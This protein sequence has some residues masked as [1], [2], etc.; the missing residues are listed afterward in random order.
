VNLKPN[1]ILVPTRGRPKNAIEVLKAH[2]EFSCRSDLLFV[3][4]TDDEELINYRTAV[5]LEYIIEVENKTR[6]MAYPINLAAKKYLNDYEFFTFIG[7][8]HRFKTA[9]WD[10]CLMR[11]I[12]NDAGLAYGNDLL[13]GQRLPT[14]VMMSAAIV[15]NLGGMV[16]PKMRHLYLDNFWKKLGEDIGNL[17][18]LEE[19]IIEHL[20]PVAGKAEW[21]EGYKAVNA[22]EIYAFD[23]LMFHNYITSEDYAVLVRNLK[24]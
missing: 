19:V 3:I 15:R 6:G 14:A 1:L 9:D 21:D 24:K 18:Y 5:G 12:G 7:D 23:R 16:P 8:D 22:E 11:A 17:S 2:K 4:D 10:V 20:H 13:Q